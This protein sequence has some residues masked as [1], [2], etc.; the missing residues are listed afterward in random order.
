MTRRTADKVIEARCW[1][2]GAQHAA[3]GAPEQGPRVAG[4][5]N[6]GPDPALN[7]EAGRTSRGRA[8]A[9]NKEPEPVSLSL[10]RTSTLP[11]ARLSRELRLADTPALAR[12]RWT[13]GLSYVGMAAGMI[14]GLYQMGV[15]RRLPDLPFAPFD[16]TKV[17]KA[18]YAYKRLQ[19]P[20]GLLMA[21]SYAVTA[22]LAGAG[23]AERARRQPLIP[24]A[25]A[26]KSIYDFL[27][28]VKLGR[29][30]WQE[31]RALCG[32][33]Q[34]AT[35]ASAASVALTLPEALAALRRLGR[36]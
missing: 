19:T 2:N 16:A 12:R 35:V 10:F 36:R 31:T 23:G 33:C 7:P 24:V 1:R 14:V 34:A 11:P 20:D 28:A 22:I 9:P 6:V 18:D 29:E 4:G 17:D 32:Y 5:R 3:A 15:L 13:L 21:A 8:G 27:L 26:A 30:E 25:L